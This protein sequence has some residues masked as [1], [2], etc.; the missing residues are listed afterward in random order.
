MGLIFVAVEVLGVV[1]GLDDVGSLH[2]ADLVWSW[3]LRG[4]DC[5]RTCMAPPSALGQVIAPCAPSATSCFHTSGLLRAFHQIVPSR[6]LAEGGDL[7]GG[8]HLPR[9]AV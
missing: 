8:S 3:G 2:S 1:G 5:Q 6:S 9:A 4:L 7:G